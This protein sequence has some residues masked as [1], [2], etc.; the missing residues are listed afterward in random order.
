MINMQI[1]MQ[2]LQTIALVTLS[3]FATVFTA[4]AAAG[5]WVIVTYDKYGRKCRT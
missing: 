4:G 3:I 1:L 5:I 2:I